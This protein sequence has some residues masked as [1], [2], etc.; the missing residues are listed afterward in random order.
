MEEL[1]PYFHAH[2]HY[3]YGCWGPVY[4]ANMLELK[5]EDLETWVFLD[6]GNFAITKQSIP[7][8]DIDPDHCIE[9]VKNIQNE[10]KRWFHR[11][12]GQ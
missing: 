2:D 8:T 1:L 6:G 12:H 4:I 9:L 10:D 5:D 3:N 7:F 11:Y